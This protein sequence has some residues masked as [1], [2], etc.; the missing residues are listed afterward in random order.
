M[1][2]PHSHTTA[3]YVPANCQC[4]CV[5]VCGESAISW[6]SMGKT[7]IDGEENQ[8]GGAKGKK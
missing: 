5:C 7:A 8:N 6:H 4:V 1:L 2:L 3:F